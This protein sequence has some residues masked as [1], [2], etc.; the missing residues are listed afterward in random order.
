LLDSARAPSVSHIGA[1]YYIPKKYSQG[2]AAAMP[3]SLWPHR[4]ALGARLHVRMHMQAAD[5]QQRS[6]S[7]FQSPALT[8]QGPDACLITNPCAQLGASSF[9]TSRASLF[10]LFVV[11]RLLFFF[12]SSPQLGAS[13]FATSRA[14]FSLRDV[15]ASS[16]LR[17]APALLAPALLAPALT[18]ARVC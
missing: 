2:K 18:P 4:A 8:Q 6:Q 14:S 17:R 13:R 3:G 11:A 7:R 15:S 12:S 9:A 10:L 1:V 16:L 5:R